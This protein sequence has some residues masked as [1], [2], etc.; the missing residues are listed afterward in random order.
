MFRFAQ[1]V[2]TFNSQASCIGP[3]DFFTDYSRRMIVRGY[4]RRRVVQGY[5]RHP[6]IEINRLPA[7]IKYDPIYIRPNIGNIALFAGFGV[8]DSKRTGLLA[9][10]PDGL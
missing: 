9:L 7:V 4:S 10:R 1:C 6:N 5:S 3:Q 8:F 2:G